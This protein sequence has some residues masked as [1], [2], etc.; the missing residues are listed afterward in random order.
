[1][2]EQQGRPK[3]GIT[4]LGCKKVR[5]VGMMEECNAYLPEVE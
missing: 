3:Q 5:V 4:F 1:M 2:P